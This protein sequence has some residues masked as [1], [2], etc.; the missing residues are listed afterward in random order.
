MARSSHSN[1][2]PLLARYDRI[3]DIDR[4]ST[5]YGDLK[6]TILNKGHITG[7]RAFKAIRAAL[8]VALRKTGKTQ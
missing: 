2:Y 3:S 4:Q 7:S 1:V 5:C 6:I 8:V